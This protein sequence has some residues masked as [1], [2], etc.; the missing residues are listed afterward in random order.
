MKNQ[1]TRNRR[2]GDRVAT[3]GRA[4]TLVE[5]LVVVSIIALLIS[6]LLP[7]L[8]TA[9]EGAKAVVCGA[10]LHDFSNGLN[11]YAA[12]ESEWI[13]GYNTSGVEIWMNSWQDPNKMSQSQLPTQTYDWMTPILRLVTEL[14]SD[15]A[16]KFRT[17]LTD[18]GCPSVRVQATLYDDDEPQDINRFVADTGEHGK[19]PGW[20]YLMPIHFQYWGQ[21]DKETL[22]WSPNYIPLTSGRNPNN[23]E[24]RIDS[25]RSRIGRVGT[26]AEKIAV[27]DGTRYLNDEG[28]L[29]FN[30][31]PR[32]GLFGAFT[33]SG[34]WWRQSTEYGDTQYGSN[35]GGRQLPLTYRHDDKIEVLFF[36]G[37]V[38]KISKKQSHKID[39]WYPRGGVVE[40]AEEGFTDYAIYENGYVI[41]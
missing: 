36:D 16:K 3:T 17:L 37:H 30:A 25:Y 8:R 10:T 4:F 35:S 40:H 22:A 38:E 21:K 5:L 27:A 6:I 18:F 2:P 7:S 29:T 24:V 31:Y 9:R 26:P 34:G 20:S 23:W 19:Y 28:M 39:Y 33:T 13:P 14:P 1:Y 41:R 11:T 15:R 32:P 12:E